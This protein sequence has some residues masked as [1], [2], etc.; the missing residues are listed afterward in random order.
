[1]GL[2]AGKCLQNLLKICCSFSFFKLILGFSPAVDF[3][4]LP[5]TCI[6]VLLRSRRLE[7]AL[8]IY[9]GSG[10]MDLVLAL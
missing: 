8:R 3:E 6:L 9:S 2:Y 4:S 10:N 1:M 7:L 5:F